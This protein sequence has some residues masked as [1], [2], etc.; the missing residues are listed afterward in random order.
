MRSFYF[1][2]DVESDCCVELIIFP[3]SHAH[4]HNSA[5][6]IHKFKPNIPAAQAV[7]MGHHNTASKAKDHAAIADPNFA[8]HQPTFSKKLPTFETQFFTLDRNDIII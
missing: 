7:P 3:V 2:N 6:F 5:E 1:D 8:V 4:H